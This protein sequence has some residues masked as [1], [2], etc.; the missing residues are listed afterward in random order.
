MM[1]KDSADGSKTATRFAERCG[2]WMGLMGW[3]M[4]APEWNQK[5]TRLTSWRPGRDAGKTAF[6]SETD[7]TAGADGKSLASWLV[8]ASPRRLHLADL[9]ETSQCCCGVDKRQG[10]WRGQR[11]TRP[12]QRVTYLSVRVQ[13]PKSGVNVSP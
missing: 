12:R 13:S 4:A 11:G 9:E 8:S 6:A 7:E 5:L 1:E 10:S 2:W 3:W